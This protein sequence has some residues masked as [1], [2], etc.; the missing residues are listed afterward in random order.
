MK[1]TITSVLLAIALTLP[2]FSQE[3]GSP[4]S[5]SD[6]KAYLERK[7]FSGAVLVKNSKGEIA[8]MVTGSA[9]VNEN[10]AIDIQA[11][12]K[13][14]SITKLFTS[15]I[16]LQLEDEGLLTLDDALNKHLQY[17]GIAYADQITIKDL[18]MHTSGLKN[19]SNAS[20][21]KAYKPD[22]LISRF[23][24]KKSNVPGKEHFYNNV[25]FLLLGKIIEAVS[26]KTFEENLNEHILKPLQMKNTGLITTHS[27]PEGVVTSF[28]VKA[29]K[30]KEELKIH[31]ENFWAAGCMYSTASDLL[32]FVEALKKGKL[33]SEKALTDL[34]TSDASLGYVAL[35]CWSFN[36]PFIEGAPRVM[37][38]RGEILGST[39]VI[40]THLDGPETVIVLSNTDEFRPE[41]FGD[42][43]NLKEYLFK[44]S[45]E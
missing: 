23:A 15:V 32:I 36:S 18:L 4:F 41:T 26:G 37:E 42:A 38:R 12:F 5:Q 19:E 44:K 7:S 24:T 1:K 10:K 13:I 20:Y 21:L 2:S 22:E 11:R 17:E 3:T 31:S 40:M 14:A 16:I 45:F 27:L 29:G 35:G 34:F 25:D 9:D 43:E 30:R 39:S 8:Q 6:L 33:L 28:K